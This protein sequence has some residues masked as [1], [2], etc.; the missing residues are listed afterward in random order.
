MAAAEAALAKLVAVRAAKP[1]GKRVR[2]APDAEP[3]AVPVVPV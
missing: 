2:G 3:A 1:P